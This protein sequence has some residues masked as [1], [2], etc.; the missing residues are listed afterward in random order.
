VRLSDTVEQRDA[1]KVI[2]IVRDS[3]EAIGVDPETGEFDVD[4]VEAGTS[5][6]QRDRIKNIKGI[7]DELEEEYEDGAPIEE[8]YERAASVGMDREKAEHEIE[9]LRRQGDIYEPTTDHLRTV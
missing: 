7:I 5:K 8:I 2:D 6:S 9:K 4:M 1:E 3:L